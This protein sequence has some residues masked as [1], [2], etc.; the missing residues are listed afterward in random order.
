MIIWV[1]I[2]MGVIIIVII[3]LT[4]INN[5]DN[6]QHSW[7]LI[8]NWN[9]LYWIFRA[10]YQVCLDIIKICICWILLVIWTK[11]YS[12]VISLKIVVTFTS[13]FWAIVLFLRLFL[14]QNTP[15]K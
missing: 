5:N 8:I 11:M 7:Y 1:I 13:H 4:I 10:F 12:I 2:I 15:N 6:Y 14:A 3:T 9:P